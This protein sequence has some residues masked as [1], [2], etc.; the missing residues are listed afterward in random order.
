MVITTPTLTSANAEAAGDDTDECDN[1]KDNPSDWISFLA[2]LVAA[3]TLE[4]GR[5]AGA[6]TIWRVVVAV[7]VGA[8]G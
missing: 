4:V 7:V 1:A 3:D 6:R 8:I 2:M 5:C